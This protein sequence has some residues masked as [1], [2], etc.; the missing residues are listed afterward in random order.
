M[1]S[2]GVDSTELPSSERVS[3]KGDLSRYRTII[4][5]EEGE[6]GQW[7][8]AVDE[9][10]TL[11]GRV[12]A[13]RGTSFLVHT[14]DQRNFDCGVRRVVNTLARE[15][16]NAVVVGDRVRLTQSGP[17]EGVI[18]RVEPR[19][20]T[21][22]R[23]T[24]RGDHLLV[25]NVDQ[26]LIVVAAADPQFK[27]NLIDRYLISAELG[28][29]RPIICVNKV[30]LVDPVRLQP[31]LGLYSQLG[32]EMLLVSVTQQKGI[33]RLK[34]ILRHRETVVTGQSGVGK[35]S[36]LNAVQ[37]GM[38]LATGEVSEETRK[39]RHTTSNATL[40]ELDFGG[41]VVDTP[42]VR[43]F[44]LSNI[45]P[46]EA[47]GIFREFR[48]YLSRCKFSSCSHTHESGCQVKQAV[49]RDLIALTRYESYLKILNSDPE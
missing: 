26:V 41:W 31:F 21:L 32:Y 25:A 28:G 2:D 23:K 13:N 36:L 5:V 46:A 18:E 16:R 6:D 48:P 27:P 1:R 4:G 49:D 11:A 20:G 19:H 8:R 43:Q 24:R 14:D 15:Q 9:N 22:S 35:S 40:L 47:C 39:G 42:G 30:D 17:A 33:E 29:V 10:Q 12:T 3:G 45:E 37:P 44:Q 7:Q 38:K 34:R